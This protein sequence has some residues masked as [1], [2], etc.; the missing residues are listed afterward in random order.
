MGQHRHLGDKA[1]QRKEATQKL[2]TPAVASPQ[3]LL[4]LLTVR[5]LMLLVDGTTVSAGGVDAGGKCERRGGQRC[6]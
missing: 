1:L 6:N 4:L 2:Y 3:P 5:M